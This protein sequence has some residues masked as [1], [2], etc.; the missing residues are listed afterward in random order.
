MSIVICGFPGVGKTCAAHDRVSVYNLDSS[1]FSWMYD[2][3]NPVEQIRN[4]DFPN[5]YVEEIKKLYNEF[6]Y[7]YILVSTHHVV[8]EE[9]KRSGIK[10]IVVAPKRALKSEYLIRYI[11][12]GS[13]MEF[14][15]ALNERWDEFL[16]GFEKEDAPVIWLESG[17]YISDIVGSLR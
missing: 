2:E 14:I 12:R 6:R 9:L 17:K 8:R 16:D 3:K 13:P 11:R 1:S 5:N 15:E 7:E 10:Y 4:P